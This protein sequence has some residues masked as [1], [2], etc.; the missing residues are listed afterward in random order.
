MPRTPRLDRELHNTHETN[1]FRQRTRNTTSSSSDFGLRASFGLR[2]SGFGFPL[3]VACRIGKVQE[4]GCSWPVGCSGPGWPSG[5]RPPRAGVTVETLRCEYLDNPLGID[6]PQPRLSWVLES[7][8]AGAEADR[9]S[10]ARGEQRGPAEGEH[11]RPLG[12]GDGDV[13][14]NATGGLCGQGAAFLPAMLL[15]SARV[16]Q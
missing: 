7:T 15:E 10:G 9:V 1:H 8:A 6:T 12:H 3:Q 5:S 4:R 16:G 13:R 11:R 2:P 14:P